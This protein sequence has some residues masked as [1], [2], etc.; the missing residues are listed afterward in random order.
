[1]TQILPAIYLAAGEGRRLRPLT[2]EQPKAML[3]I[4]GA[5]LAERALRALRGAGVERVV[6]VTGHAR[7]K[8]DEVD[9]L[10]SE[11]VFNPHFADANNVY[12]LWC[13]RDVVSGGCYIINSDVLFERAI[14]DRLVSA[15]GSAV[16]CASDHG[17]DHESMKAVSRDGRLVQLSKAAPSE[18]NPEYIGLT[19]IDPSEGPPLVSIL[20]RIVADELTDVYYEDAL[21]DLAAE[22]AVGIVPVDGLAWIE[23]DDT[24]DLTR[25]R[26]E[27][28][29]RVG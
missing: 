1:M 18:G 22:A 13:A 6:A 15:S 10:L 20:E 29:E 19:R 26:G 5:T 3:E 7:E 16:L 25:A 21:N 17:A 24:D 23:I 8:L 28:L 4:G 27:I 11:Q 14:A 9:G 2:D 12:S